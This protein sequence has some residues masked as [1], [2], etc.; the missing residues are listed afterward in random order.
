[1]GKHQ[2]N[3]NT[4]ADEQQTSTGNAISAISTHG[5]DNQNADSVLESKHE[6]EIFIKQ[7]PLN[8]DCPETDSEELKSQID[9]VKRKICG[10][11]S[12]EDRTLDDSNHTKIE[13]KIE[14][15]KSVKT[16]TEIKVIC[17]YIN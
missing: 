10:D 2:K 14:P 4:S 6:V 5:H 17:Y 9:A 13:V 7:E 3:A 11:S 8:Q 12:D 16:D 1:M 15:I